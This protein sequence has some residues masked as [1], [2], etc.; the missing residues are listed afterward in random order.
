MEGESNSSD[1]GSGESQAKTIDDYRKLVGAWPY[2]R[3]F[4]LDTMDENVIERHGELI[5]YRALNIGRAVA[6]VGA[7]VSMSYGRISWRE[8]VR[9]LYMSISAE[10]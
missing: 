8:L 2:A 5:L 7:G 4:V 9:V 3:Q 6:F 10:I 1:A